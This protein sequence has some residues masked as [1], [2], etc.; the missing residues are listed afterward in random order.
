[1][2][3]KAVS[4][5]VR[6]STALSRTASALGIATMITLSVWDYTRA[7]KKQQKEDGRA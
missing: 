5:L 7:R 1:M 4:A 3:W 2:F 6:T